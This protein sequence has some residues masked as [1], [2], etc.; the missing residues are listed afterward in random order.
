MRTLTNA[1]VHFKWTEECQKKFISMK[2][3]LGSMNFLAP[4]DIRRP[5]ELF[6]DASKEG[7]LRFVLWQ[8]GEEK[9][10]SIIQCGSTGLTATQKNYSVTEVE[11]LEVVWSLEW[12]WG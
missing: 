10:K 2:K 11:L 8:P 1:N 12:K 9:H 3:I 4:F 5:L 6:T 7:G